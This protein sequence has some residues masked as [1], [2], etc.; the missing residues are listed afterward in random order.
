MCV[1]LIHKGLAE[2]FFLPHKT[3]QLLNLI[4]GLIYIG[5]NK[6]DLV[7]SNYSQVGNTHHSLSS[8]INIH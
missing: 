5:W 4:S 1:Y 7:S 2:M 3:S 6:H 8:Q